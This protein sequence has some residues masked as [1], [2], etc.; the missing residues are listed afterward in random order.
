MMKMRMSGKILTMNAAAPEGA[1]PPVAAKAGDSNI[2]PSGLRRT[3]AKRAGSE[4]RGDYHGDPRLPS[5]GAAP[6]CGTCATVPR[7]GSSSPVRGGGPCE[8]WWRGCANLRVGSGPE[9]DQRRR[10]MREQLALGRAQIGLGR[11]D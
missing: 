2:L 11:R 5:E 10:P 1:A 7:P 9:D 4:A 3:R 8:A 6:A